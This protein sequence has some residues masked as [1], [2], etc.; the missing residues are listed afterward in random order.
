[1]NRRAIAGIASAPLV[2]CLTIAPALGRAGGDP[3]PSQQRHAGWKSLSRHYGYPYVARWDPC[4]KI[5]YRINAKKADKGAVRDVKKAVRRIERASGLRFK[6]RGRTKVVP[7]TKHLTKMPKDTRFV[8]AWV[9]KKQRP[10]M[11][12]NVQGRGTLN[13][14]EYRRHGKRKGIGVQ[15]YVLVNTRFNGKLSHGFGKPPADSAGSRG[16]MLMHELGHSVGLWHVKQRDEIMY[17]VN[18]RKRA[19]WG[20]GDRNGLKRVGRP[21]G[22]FTKPGTAAKR[23]VR[24]GFD[25]AAVLPARE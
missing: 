12:K 9:S 21:A 4:K 13:W 19:G 22:C 17:R 25:P 18:L 8:I 15:G 16:R 20:N 7:R 2:V 23:V 24:A 3:A 6:Y 10:I 5:G 1:M 11:T 14:R